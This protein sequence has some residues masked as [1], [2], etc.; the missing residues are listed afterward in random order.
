LPASFTTSTFPVTPTVLPVTLSAPLNFPSI[1]A[2]LVLPVSCF[3]AV[4]PSRSVASVAAPV[5]NG[6][7]VA[8]TGCVAW[9]NVPLTGWVTPDP[10]TFSLP[11][12]ESQTLARILTSP[13][14]L[15]LMVP[16]ASDETAASVVAPRATSFPSAT[17]AGM[18]LPLATSPSLTPSAP[19]VNFV[20]GNCTPPMSSEANVSPPA[21]GLAVTLS[22]T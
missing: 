4:A 8:L 3:A 10:S 19:S 21:P 1:L 9:K 15:P 22:A 7:A 12:I 5:G 20:R 14:I 13:L 6:S 18:G 11:L 17:L 2:R 16:V